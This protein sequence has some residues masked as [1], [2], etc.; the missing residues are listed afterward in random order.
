MFAS[1][2][3]YLELANLGDW[4]SRLPTGARCWDQISGQTSSS[5]RWEQSWLVMTMMPL[6]RIWCTTSARS[7]TGWISNTRTFAHGGQAIAS[8]FHINIKFHVNVEKLTEP[9][10][11]KGRTRYWTW[12]TWCQRSKAGRSTWPTPSPLTQPPSSSTTC[13]PTLEDSRWFK[14]P[15]GIYGST[16]LQH[17]LVS[18][19]R[20]IILSSFL[21]STG[22]WHWHSGEDWSDIFDIFLGSIGGVAGKAWNENTNM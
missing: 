15:V 11:T 2:P 14:Y 8:K 21:T 18:L 9:T 12:W 17:S 5:L 19:R 16:I 3:G 10:L 22:F 13:L 7:M 4:L 1:R 6:S 20:I